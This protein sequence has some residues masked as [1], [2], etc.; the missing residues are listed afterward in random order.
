IPKARL[1]AFP[2]VTLCVTCKQLEE[3]R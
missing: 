2:T 3:R 1:E